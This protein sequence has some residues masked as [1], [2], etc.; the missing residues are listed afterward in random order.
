MSPRSAPV[1]AL[2]WILLTPAVLAQ[3]SPASPSPPPLGWRLSLPEGLSVDGD[4]LQR[5]VTGKGCAGRLLGRKE[6]PFSEAQVTCDAFL[7]FVLVQASLEGRAPPDVRE[8]L[9]ALL[10]DALGR[11]RAPF[12]STGSTLVAGRTLPRSGLY[13]GLLLL[14]LAGMERAGLARDE[15]RVLFDALAARTVEDLSHQP[16][17]P[18]FGTSLWPCDNALVASGLLLHGRLR[19]V[20]SS[21]VAGERL[22]AHLVALSQRPEGFPTQ[23]DAKGRAVA[24]TPRGSA[25]AWTAAFLAMSGHPAARTFADVL[26]EDFCERLALFPKA[27]ACREWPR[28]VERPADAASGPLLAGYGQGAT[29][30]AIA[31]TRA[32]EQL[33]PWHL[34]LRTTA[35][36]GGIQEHVSRPER[37]PLETAL[38]AWATGLTP[39]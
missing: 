32:S 33:Q 18:S 39:W 31:A 38:Y 27:A 37:Y 13:R 7:S 35:V 6:H 14:M 2:S 1:L 15:D 8:R 11:G 9:A 36:L 28:G 29:A 26:L 12:H 10:A 4:A 17:L 34:D 16:L 25:L 24:K 5:Q 23:V 20:A 21:R 30:L 22:A 19:G 3:S